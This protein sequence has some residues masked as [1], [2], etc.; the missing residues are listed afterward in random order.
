MQDLAGFSPMTTT[1]EPKVH[2][3]KQVYSFPSNLGAFPAAPKTGLCGGS[4]PCRDRWPP[5]VAPPLQKQIRNAFRRDLRPLAQ[6]HPF[7]VSVFKMPADYADY[8]DFRARN[9]RMARTCGKWTRDGTTG[10]A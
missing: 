5:A 2:V 4:V 3:V 6:L 1:N 9:L 10:K 7:G 8:A